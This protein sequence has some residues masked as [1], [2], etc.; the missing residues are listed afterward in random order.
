MR[1]KGGEF[2]GFHYL[3]WTL[4]L[5]LLSFIGI[6]FIAPLLG[7]TVGKLEREAFEAVGLGFGAYATSLG[8]LIVLWCF[9]VFSRAAEEAKEKGQKLVRPKVMLGAGV[10]LMLSATLLYFTARG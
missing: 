1:R 2:L 4:A 9:S 7:V 3:E 6:H 8:L 10:A 5:A